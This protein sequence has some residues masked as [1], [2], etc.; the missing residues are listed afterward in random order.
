MSCWLC[1]DFPVFS[2]QWKG[3]Y[4]HYSLKEALNK[5][6]THGTFSAPSRNG[7]EEFSRVSESFTEQ[8][9]AAMRNLGTTP[10]PEPVGPKMIVILWILS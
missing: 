3:I 9:P 5:Q 8:S 7:A 6:G 10:L 2:L 1:R 4:I